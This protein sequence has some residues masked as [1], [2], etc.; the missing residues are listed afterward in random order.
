M[1]VS[2]AA[3]D[4]LM[5]ALNADMAA[6][7][8][9]VREDLRRALLVQPLLL[10][11]LRSSLQAAG[12]QALAVSMRS[13][14]SVS[15]ALAGMARREVQMLEGLEV[16]LRQIDARASKAAA[17]S[18]REAAAE[19]MSQVCAQVD[20]RL[21]RVE[22]VARVALAAVVVTAAAAV[23]SVVAMAVIWAGSSAP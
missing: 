15:A 14:E 16:T 12:D 23:L 2:R 3:A 9:L 10:E 20:R 7:L 17:E 6:D 5:K 13:A 22:R 19:A 18:A 8:Q 11:D 4:A 1:K 21:Q